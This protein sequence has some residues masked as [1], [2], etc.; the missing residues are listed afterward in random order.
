MDAC[1]QRLHA[2][3]IPH[4][5]GMFFIL[6]CDLVY[7]DQAFSQFHG[8]IHSCHISSSSCTLFNNKPIQG[9]GFYANVI[10]VSGGEAE[11][12]VSY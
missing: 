2:S 12:F 9:E 7:G 11:L 1:N 4:L 10:D 6:V 5:H 8:P 3:I